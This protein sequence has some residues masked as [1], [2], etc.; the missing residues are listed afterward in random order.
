SGDCSLIRGGFG[1]T[2]TPSGFFTPFSR[3]SFHDSLNG[4]QGHRVASQVSNSGW[5][6]LN[7]SSF[8]QEVRWVLSQVSN[9]GLR[10]AFR[11]SIALRIK[12]PA[13]LSLDE[14]TLARKDST[15]NGSPTSGTSST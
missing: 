4:Q 1:S 12:L 9:S 8:S 7:F 10:W 15:S 3:L 6:A 2:T 13:S 14:S 5:Y 11:S